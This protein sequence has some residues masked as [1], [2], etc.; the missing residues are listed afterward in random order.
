MAK[1]LYSLLLNTEVI[2]EIDK[3]AYQKQTSRSAFINEILGEFVSVATP[4]KRQR[5]IF[6]TLQECVQEH[7]TMQ[8]MVTNSNNLL[9]IRSP[10]QYQYNPTIRYSVS[11]ERERKQTSGQIKFSIRTQNRNLLALLGDFFERLIIL[12]TQGG[13]NLNNSFLVSQGKL[14]KTFALPSSSKS[15]TDQEIGQLVANYLETVDEM[16][17]V[18]FSQK[19]KGKNDFSQLEKIYLDYL[20]SQ[21]I[22]L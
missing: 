18:Y 7:D 3:L 17:G 6:D 21:P 15:M 11:I 12:E 19:Q 5:T 8:L 10:L 2:E 14:I 22:H 20:Q 1:I 13:S 4:Q 9:L 16:L